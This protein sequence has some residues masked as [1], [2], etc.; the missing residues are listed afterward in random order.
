LVVLTTEWLLA[1]QVP[2]KLKDCG[3]ERCCW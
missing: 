2:V 1:T 3:Y